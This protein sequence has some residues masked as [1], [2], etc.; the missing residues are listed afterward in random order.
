MFNW[1][2]IA[3]PLARHPWTVQ[4]TK[5]ALLLTTAVTLTMVLSG[6]VGAK[7]VP[8]FM[9]RGARNAP[10][11][12]ARS[13]LTANAEARASL[14]LRYERGFTS[15]WYS[16]GVSALSNPKTGVYCI[17]PIRPIKSTSNPQ[18]TLE[19]SY[20]YGSSFVDFWENGSF[21]Y[22]SGNGQLEI[23]TYDTKGNLTE[24]SAFVVI[25]NN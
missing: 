9:S 18:V 25:I 11:L 6:S 23:K 12:K 13:P 7:N 19:W 21:D 8:G 16:K 4:M 20:S 17:T 15:A 5:S 2:G 3:K 1:L 22:P 24:D 14:V 10:F